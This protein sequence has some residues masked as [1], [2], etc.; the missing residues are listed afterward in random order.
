M[1]ILYLITMTEFVSTYAY[2]CLFI[3]LLHFIIYL[4]KKAGTALREY[5][6]ANVSQCKFIHTRILVVVGLSLK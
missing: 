2:V 1:K 4:R 6:C 3:S 5:S